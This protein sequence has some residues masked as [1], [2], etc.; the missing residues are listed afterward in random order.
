M[1][2]I[3]LCECGCGEPAPIAKMND[4][5]RGHIKGQPIRF[6]H[7]HNSVSER[8][9]LDRIVLVPGT[10]AILLTHGQVAIVDAADFV[11][12]SQWSWHAKKDRSTFYVVRNTP[13]VNGRRDTISMHQ[14]IC[15]KGAD[16]I[17]GDGLNNTR[18]NLRLAT[19][20][21]NSCNR[22][23]NKNSASGF[24]GV[25]WYKPRRKWRARIGLDGRKLHLGLFTNAEDA[26]MAYDAAARELHGEFARTNYPHEKTTP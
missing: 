3:K 2:E 18:S 22:G 23:A 15:G 19:S 12:L 4:K 11:W 21:Q 20:R 17:D 8:T 14:M 13:T 25:T 24:K 26:A 5:R 7:G 10:R 6:V 1:R 16:H 9:S